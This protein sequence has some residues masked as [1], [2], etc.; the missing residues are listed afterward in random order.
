MK[1]DG[2]RLEGIVAFVEK[3]LLPSGFEVE[4]NRREHDEQGV[5]IAEFDVSVRGKIG[6][7]DFNW[8]IE[9]RDRPSSGAA[10]GAWIEQLVGRR[11]R[12]GFNKVTAVSTTGFAEGA[13]EWAKTSGIE[14]REVASLTPESFASWLSI[15]GVISDTLR[16]T[17]RSAHL[18]LTEP[19]SEERRQAALAL[20]QGL[21][22]DKRILKVASGERANLDEAF[23]TALGSRQEVW[24][25]AV[26]N[27]PARTVQVTANYIPEARFTIETCEGD[28][29]VD[30]IVFAG[31]INLEREILPLA[32]TQEYRHMGAGGAISQV[33]TYAP[34]AVMGMKF[35]TEFHRLEDTGETHILMRR[36]E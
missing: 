24:A 17:L 34:H 31:E 3:T 4:V 27:G 5:Q 36:V 25:D 23:N 28:V 19:V 9:C 11:Q 21:G 14:L 22:S 1:S 30:V 35:V 32:S 29:E 8:L 15:P 2:K 7:S 20:I 10:P 33:A 16:T 18:H 12:F 6:T 13:V 26:P